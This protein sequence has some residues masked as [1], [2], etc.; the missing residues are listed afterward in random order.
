LAVAF[1]QHGIAALIYDKRGTA[2]SSGDWYAASLDEL[3]GD[4]LSAVRYLRGRTEIRPHQVG[5]WGLSQGGWIVPLA[6]ARSDGVAF[7]ITV[8]AAG[9]SPAQ[10]ELYR[11]S[12]LL[13][14]LGYEGRTL[15]A[16]MKAVRL[17]FDLDRLDLPGVDALFLGLDFQHD[18]VPVLEQVSQ[19]VLA[20]WG[21][22]D[23]VVPP[24]TSA[25]IFAEALQRGSTQDVT[26]R[27]LSG[28]GHSMQLADEGGHVG[29]YP[30]GY[31]DAMVDWVRERTEG[32]DAALQ[33][34]EDGSA[35]GLTVEVL[36]PATLPWYGTAPVQLAAIGMFA[37]MFALT[38]TGWPITYAVQLLKGQS[39]GDEHRARWLD[40][41][42]SLGSLLNL[43]LLIGLVGAL[44]QF[45]MADDRALARYLELPVVRAAAALAS[46][47]VLVWVVSAALAWQRPRLGK[48]AAVARTIAA[49]AAVA[50]L[51]HLLYWNL[52][53]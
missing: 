4:A 5:L 34:N 26:I 51:P 31:V 25:R 43:G 50:Y 3:A 1:A 39:S 29:A 33:S 14:T 24:R 15:D 11:W 6:A 52:P 36:P 10:Q 18:P 37:L 8:S 41:L 32:G 20:I 12:N 13:P 28:A 30:P 17:Q 49:V 9:V 16:A 38:G 19:P 7:V 22:A 46:L 44:F 2:Q 53:W 27:I 23:Q 48:R 45:L 21:A 40:L 47:S 35:P 42:A